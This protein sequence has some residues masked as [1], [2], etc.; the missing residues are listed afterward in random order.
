[1]SEL[2]DNLHRSVREPVR[3]LNT[4]QGEGYFSPS[5]SRRARR[6]VRAANTESRNTSR[7]LR[8]SGF[9][10]EVDEIERELEGKS[11]TALLFDG[12]QAANFAIAGGVREVQEGGSW[13]DALKRGA[14]ELST[15]GT[16]GMITDEQ[17]GE[18]FGKA[19]QRESFSD[20]LRASADR[21]EEDIPTAVA[22][23]VL[24]IVLDPTTYVTAGAGIFG[25]IGKLAPFVSPFAA[26]AKGA[27]AVSRT[28]L[29]QRKITAFWSQSENV[30]ANLPNLLGRSFSPRFKWEQAIREAD[31]ENQQALAMFMSD[32]TVRDIEQ[33]VG[34]DS[35][36]AGLA[37]LV[38]EG[39]EAFANK[40]GVLEMTGAVEPFKNRLD[41]GVSVKDF[42]TS[43]S[44]DMTQM[45]RRMM[46][47]FL[48]RP[49][50]LMKIVR[51][52]VPERAAFI[53][54]K[55][56][57]FT[58]YFQLLAKEENKAGLWSHLEI[59]DFYAPGTETLSKE[60]QKLMQEMFKKMGIGKNRDLVLEQLAPGHKGI[61]GKAFFEMEK[62][63]LSLEQRV[64]RAN[65]TELDISAMAVNR[66]FHST[67]RMANKRLLDAVFSNPELVKQIRDADGLLDKRA[68]SLAQFVKK[69]GD[70]EGERMFKKRN[71]FN[72]RLESKN[73]EVY[74]P[75]G[76]TLDGE[77]GKAGNFTKG[78]RFK[79]GDTVY[80][81]TDKGKKAKDARVYREG[82]AA[83]A[84]DMSPDQPVYR[85]KNGKLHG[86]PVK[87]SSING[88]GR[89]GI[90]TD[91]G[92]EFYKVAPEGKGVDASVSTQGPEG[93]KI[94]K[95]DDDVREVT[96]AAAY[97]MPKEMADEL[98]MV[99]KAF[100]G[101][102]PEARM[103][104]AGFDKI[105]SIWKGY[106]VMSPGFH[107]RNMQGNLF[108]NWLGGVPLN[109]KKYAE[110]MKL[111]AGKSKGV[112]IVVDGKTYTDNE[113][114]R[115][116]DVHGIRD[117]GGFA[118]D[119]GQIDREADLLTSLQR[120]AGKD[121]DALR[122]A[123]GDSDDPLLQVIAEQN[124]G[125]GLSKIL[126]DNFGSGGK[127]LSVNRDVGRAVE[128]NAKLVHFIHKL[129]KG[130]SAED[131]AISTKK[132]LFDYGSLTDWE[133]KTMRRALPFYTWVRKNVPLMYSE[134]F[135]QPGK[136]GALPK[137][138]DAIEDLTSDANDVAT[139]DYFQ[140]ITAIRMPA[141]VDRGV[142]DINQF[143]AQV[144]Y[145]MEILKEKPEE[146]TGLQPVYLKPDLP[147]Q[148][149]EIGHKD[150][151]SGLSP[152]LRVPFEMA[153]GQQNRGFSFF[154]DRPIERFE[155]QDAEL[156]AIPGLP[157][158][159]RAKHQSALE[160]LIPTLGKFN[161]L[162][163]KAQKGQLAAQFSSEFL[164]LK[165]IQND[166]KQAKA[167]KASNRR[168]KLRSLKR[169]LRD[170]G[171]VR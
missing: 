3:A 36:S 111:Q 102:S 161:R 91:T 45:E 85:I 167:V 160:S 121:G 130:M 67:R 8:R 140:E 129:R 53:E 19:P 46:G 72:A 44:A 146:L 154:L 142:R 27:R 103:L 39:G 168:D 135:K 122:K 101:G 13:F 150:L 144:L 69:F 92:D 157:F 50:E 71:T 26:A 141:F 34:T 57:S 64:L 156:S 59:K 17:A 125:R 164:G 24:D 81:V 110:A 97:I 20:V 11:R 99:D 148:D 108:L 106:A 68:W 7:H 35:L 38:K 77:I 112:S 118:Q 134:L 42:V 96:S 169:R 82:K 166:V 165:V 52:A 115:L 120:R 123:L 40:G 15:S 23:L 170:R 70:L 152:M 88:K 66:G 75:V 128:N 6:S 109:P 158:H 80:T 119:I 117:T 84:F 1:M 131:A 149:L 73:L 4:M 16:F 87:L 31:P 107:V 137:G 113:I 136:F 133:R 124:D 86:D 29:G 79:V 126:R 90:K 171:L 163:S 58:D 105:Q 33:F 55:L 43:L 147:F 22:G 21:G 5:S 104:L 63:F 74:R 10:R 18:F 47:L 132:Y 145:S 143:M 114:I 116:A 100:K 51:D 76:H 30:I 65:G 94:F 54:Q 28:A 32:L 153:A 61:E 83:D 37:D 9:G 159:L 89:F 151:I 155:G 93:V 25:K 139:P 98:G 127:L 12:L 48:D 62:K 138:F 2:L 56:A 49:E 78:S 60:S 95:P 41:Q 162:R 14:A